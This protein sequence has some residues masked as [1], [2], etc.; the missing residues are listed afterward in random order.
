M[1]YTPKTLSS[2]EDE[3]AQKAVIDAFVSTLPAPVH[4]LKT[5]ASYIFLSG[6]KAFKIK[7]ALKYP[8]LDYST[9]D[10]RRAACTA[11]YKINKQLS[12]QLYIDALPLMKNEHGALAL[13]GHGTPVEWVLVMK[14]FADGDLFSQRAT[15]G[16]LTPALIIA[17]TENIARM[18][19]HARI[20]P[21]DEPHG[22]GAARFAQIMA[23]TTNEIMASSN[24]GMMRR[25]AHVAPSLSGYLSQFS[26]ILDRRMETGH[27]RACHGDL[28]LGNICVFNGDP[29]LFDAVE[30]NPGISKIDTLYDIAFLWMDLVAQGELAL[31]NLS[32]NTYMAIMGGHQDLAVLP[33]FMA[34]RALIRMK[35]ALAR[36]D[37][38]EA[39]RYLDLAATWVPTQRPSLTA[40]GGLS[41]SGKTTAAAALAPY[42]G[43]PP[44][45]IH[46][47]SDLV[48]KK[49][50]GIP[51][52][53][54]APSAAY[55]PV[56][57]T[58]VYETLALQADACLQAHW[59]VVVDAMFQQ[60]A[61]RHA[62]EHKALQAKVPFNGLWLTAPLEARLTR[63]AERCNDASDADA[64]VLKS[65]EKGQIRPDNWQSVDSS[66]PVDETL[67]AIRS[68]STIDSNQRRESTTL[69]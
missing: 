26:H 11:E 37:I 29:T 27:V 8:Y 53:T 6:D 60:P 35:V 30:F 43:L 5:H 20:I 10:L 18:H 55:T 3:A 46:L 9:L 39:D 44:G 34:K 24:P 66:L 32:F 56:A 62:I 57:T 40:I 42:I 61:A 51:P 21:T 41:G 23:E 15:H 64:A 49:C 14:R 52:L 36:G 17:A 25:M 12:P 63:V 2:S 19:Q 65:Q 67:N 1:N 69:F 48:R 68:H 22:G 7:R 13:G 45:A 33:L 54:H 38:V 59:P 47:R 50:F 31:A 4:R 58:L 28:H 16:T